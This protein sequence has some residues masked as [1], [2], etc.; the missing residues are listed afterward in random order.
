MRVR[1]LPLSMIDDNRT[2]LQEIMRVRKYLEENPIRNIFFINAD[3]VV[4]TIAYNVSDIYI[5]NGLDVTASADD[6]LV[7]K[8]GYIGII[9][10]M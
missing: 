1:I 4:G 3:Y 7:F 5:N 2:I 6:G 9:D 8:N 10:S